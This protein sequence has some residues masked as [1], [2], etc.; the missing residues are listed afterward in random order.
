VNKK[1]TWIIVVLAAAALLGS[2][3]CKGGGSGSTA[4]VWEQKVVL[5]T[6]LIDKGDT[7]PRFYNGRVYQGAQGRVYPW[8]IYERLTDNKVDK[9][10][11]ALYLENE[12]IQVSMLPEIGGRIFTGL[13]KTNNYD[14]IYKQHVVKPGLIGMLGAWITGGVE[15]NVFHHHRPTSYLPV[16]HLIQ[17]NPDGSA[18]AWVGEIEIRQRMKWAI[19][20]TVYPGKSYIEVT[21]KPFNRTPMIESFLY[22]ANVGV[23]ANDN[24]QVVFPPSTEWV[25]QHAKR[26]F[27]GWPIAHE[28]YNRV[29]FSQGVDISW[30]KNNDKQIS[31]FCWNYEDDFFAGYDHGKEAG[32]CI[33]A[34]HNTV[35]GKKFWEWGSGERGKVWDKVL[36]EGDGPELE[37]MSGG[38]SDNEPDYS[39]IQPYESKVAR[40]YFYPIRKLGKLKNA[41]PEAAVSLEVTDQNVAKI[42]FNATSKRTGAKALLQAGDQTLLEDAINIDPNT[43]YN[44]DLNL[45]AGVKET[46]LRVSLLASDGTELVAYKPEPK[47]G[48]PMPPAVKAPAAPKDMKTVEELYLAGVRIDQFHHPNWDP[49]PYWEEALKRDP[50]ESRVNI[51]VGIV[52]MRQAKVEEA[53]R[54]FKTALARVNA[55]YYRPREGEAY[56]YHGLALKYLGKYAEAYTDLYQATW[57]EGFTAAAYYELARIDSLRGEF[58]KALDHLDRSLATNAANVSALDLKAVALRKLGRVEEAAAVAAQASKMDVLDFWS[59][60][61]LALANSA[62]SRKADAQTALEG[63]KLL[64]RDD[65]Q[66]HLELSLEYGNIGLWDDG[67]AVLS[68]LI[69]Q[70]ATHPLIYYYVGYYSEKKGYKA[71]ADQYYL[72]ASKMPPDYCFPFR[73]EEVGIL[74]AA[75]AS[76][77]K[78]AMAPYYLGNLLYEKQPAEGIKQWEK[79]VSLGANFATLHRNLGYG[80]D[81]IEKNIPKALA[82]YEKAIECNPKDTRIIYEYDA[83]NEKA[84]TPP[85]KRLAFLEKHHETLAADGYWMP[86]ECE[87]RLDVQLGRYDKA[88]ELAKAFHYRR[89]E[90]GANVHTSFVDA[91]ILRGLELLKAKE[92]DKALKYMEEAATFPLNMEAA[93]DFAGGRTC[94]VF[95][96]TGTVY[97][98]MG[99]K[100][101]AKEYYEKAVAERQYYDELEVSHYFR[102]QA[103]KKLG[104]TAEAEKLFDGLIK[105]EEADLRNIE[106][107][108]GLSFFAKFGERDT[109]EVRKARA[110]YLIGLGYQGK[111]AAARARSEYETAARLNINLL[112]ARAMINEVK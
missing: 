34:D 111:G 44:K 8:P 49:I 6:Y 17:Q 29:D 56:Y 106:T 4:R 33:V 77:P 13:D 46:D 28:V 32:T 71:G 31:Y 107:S 109:P 95:Y 15:W 24:Y 57:S 91:N 72:Q 2:L 94:E 83:L 25:T 102:G 37:L 85:E 69:E 39:F 45:P 61:E 75:M 38:Y 52:K 88:I 100:D 21:F 90:G 93:E 110:H 23:H 112:W 18:T 53:E 30:W 43:P 9:T 70:K 58:A 99:N 63:L 84:Q 22:F 35:P 76:N 92:Y 67:L 98:A 50:G 64:T 55:S 108:T 97:E 27:A 68:R 42:G 40:Q 19:G 87:A 16:D 66:S 20:V 80:Y 82:S 36:S 89:W 101:K 7:N 103:L 3:A 54:Y 26:E 96:R 14:F 59:R 105:Q 86:L 5:P 12:Y 81:L 10:Y 74:Q 65:V 73:L 48:T 47:R 41:T 104:K 51:A 78:D 62:L 60:N 1:V 79:A 11:N